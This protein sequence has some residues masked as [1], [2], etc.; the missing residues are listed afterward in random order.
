MPMGGGGTNLQE[1]SI[2]NADKSGSLSFP[3]NLSKYPRG[4]YYI[5]VK[6]TNGE[7]KNREGGLAI[8]GYILRDAVRT[9]WG[10]P[11]SIFE[12]K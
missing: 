7:E 2:E 6:K 9:T 8:V 5:R 4:V 3:L 1:T 12:K 11:Y 10:V